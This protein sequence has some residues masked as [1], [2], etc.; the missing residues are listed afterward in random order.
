[1]RL[2][3]SGRQRPASLN[4]VVAEVAAAVLVHIAFWLLLLS[5]LSIKL[6]LY[7]IIG[8]ALFP[9]LLYFVSRL[10]SIGRLTPVY[11]LFLP[12]LVELVGARYFVDGFREL[13]YTL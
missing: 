9:V 6:E 12:L 11:A 10:H 7:A 4:A 8:L 13:F 3:R 5:M 2:E 1:M